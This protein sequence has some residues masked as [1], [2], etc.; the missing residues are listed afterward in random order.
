MIGYNSLKKLKLE[1][2]LTIG[3]FG[4]SITEAGGSN[5]RLGW[6]GR[7]TDAIKALYPDSDIKEIQAAIGG[8]GSDLGAFRIKNDL[9]IHKP[10]LI[11]IEFAVNDSGTAEKRI[12]RSID[13]IV[14]SIIKNNPL[15]DIIFIYTT[16]ASIIE[17]VNNRKGYSSREIMSRICEHYNIP[18]IDIGE[19]LKEAIEN[20]ET[21]DNLAPDK[22]HPSD[23]GHAL[24]FE[25][26]KASMPEY[27][28]KNTD[29][30]SNALHN[31]LKSPY[32][33]NPYDNCCVYDAWNIECSNGFFKVDKSLS[34]RYPH[35]IEGKAGAT[36][37]LT[38]KGDILGLYWLI[39]P[40]SGKI[41]LSV[42][43][44]KERIYSSWDS[45]ALNFTRAGYLIINED[46]N[47]AEHTLKIRVL[48]E[49]DNQSTGSIV[50]IGAFL[51]R[52]LLY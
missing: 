24:Y 11:F 33:D 21:W 49:K 14:R 29:V 31:E 51:I 34:G 5:G 40:D 15:S 3:Y 44:E 45:Y 13:G 25:K 19:A 4:G 43:D 30:S 20:G 38:F 8:T 37:S 47:K 26:L 35:Y 50:R 27:F 39:A 32:S 22:V 2:K 9:L 42:D 28:N 52:D 36:L 10:D 46:L 16:T 41:A 48:E 1:K 23:K 6:R 7:T 12:S 17:A 18:Y